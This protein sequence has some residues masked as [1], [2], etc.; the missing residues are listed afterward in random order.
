M[1]RPKQ[2]AVCSP[3]SVLAL[4]RAVR[5]EPLDMVE[6][7]AYVEQRR[8]EYV[9]RAE[10]IA[11]EA[12]ERADFELELKAVAFCVRLTSLWKNRVDVNANHLGLVKAPDLSKATAAEL[13]AINR[14]DETI[15]QAFAKK[16]SDPNGDL[17]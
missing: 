9:K 16:A 11:D 17:N 2:N 7:S 5:F 10:L 4:V 14:G 15:I 6:P 3:D 1:G 8:L 13:D 12:R